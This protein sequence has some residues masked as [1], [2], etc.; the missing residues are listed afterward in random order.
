MQDMTYRRDL[1]AARSALAARER[2]FLRG[3]RFGTIEY[4][5]RGDGTPVLVSHPLFGGFDVGLGIARTYVG[6]DFRVIAP[7]RFGYLGSSLPEQAT[8]ADQADA[9]ATLLDALGIDRVA[10]FGYSAGGPSTIQFA[11]RH[12][13]RTAALVLLASALPGEAGGPP[14]AVA[15]LLFGSDLFFW[16]L[17]RCA[18]ALL[19]RM[20]GMPKGWRPSPPEQHAIDDAAASMYPFPPRKRGA[21]YDLYVSTPDVQRYPLEAVTAP[22]LVITAKDDGLSAAQNAV[23][24]ADRIPEAQLL[25]FPHGGHLLLGHE[26]VI[27]EKVHDFVSRA[28][29]SDARP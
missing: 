27:R 22:T 13:D 10:M 15:Q 29:G 9:F 23:R 2:D 25:Q 16:T 1:K 28:F 12:A 7:S 21:L 14:K 17:K 19:D 18:P 11:L 4:A 8:P 24:G 3:T 20:L 5:D 6:E 26:A